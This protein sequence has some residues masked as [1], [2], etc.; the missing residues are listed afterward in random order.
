MAKLAIGSDLIR[1]KW[2]TD[3]LIKESPNSVFSSYTGDSARSVIHVEKD[4]TAAHG[5]T[6]VFEAKGDTSN[7]PIYGDDQSTGKGEIKRKYSTT[8]TVGKYRFI[9]KNSTPF[10]A[11]TAGDLESKEHSESIASLSRGYYA[12]KDQMIF[13]TAQS[14]LGVAA[15]HEIDLTSTFDYNSLLQIDNK[16]T[17][18]RGHTIGADRRPLTPFRIKGGKAVNVFMID[19]SMALKLRTSALFQNIMSVS[20]VRGEN[21]MLINGALGMIGN[22][23]LVEAPNFFG[24]TSS[25][26]SWEMKESGVEI[27]GL[28]Q[29]DREHGAWTGQAGFSSTPAAGKLE[30]YGFVLGSNAIQFGIG[31]MP[32]YKQAGQILESTSESQLE[33]WMG[34]QKTNY[35]LETGKVSA[36][37]HTDLDYGIVRVKLIVN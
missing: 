18:G 21:N 28:R 2:I 36:A 6:I 30:S 31:K 26:A 4:S 13:D 29:Y 23:L 8:T 34:V 32:E 16:I 27:A 20:D 15:T 10:D 5:H 17:T 35:K 25:G 11:V 33:T 19:S 1:K 12:F 37:K 22:L 7:K 24:T 3:N 14:T 9:V